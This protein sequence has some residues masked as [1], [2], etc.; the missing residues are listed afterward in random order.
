MAEQDQETRVSDQHPAGAAE[1]SEQTTAAEPVEHRVGV[2]L[3][4]EGVDE[5]HAPVAGD[6]GH[7]DVHPRVAGH[8]DP[9]RDLPE[10]LAALLHDTDPTAPAL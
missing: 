1:G 5:Q 6:G 4:A 8:P 3:A 2:A 9:V 10:L 7:V